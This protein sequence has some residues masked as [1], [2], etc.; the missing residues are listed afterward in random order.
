MKSYLII[1]TPDPSQL[2]QAEHVQLKDGEFVFLD[3][4]RKE[5]FRIPSDGHS[6]FQAIDPGAPSVY[7]K[8]GV[9]TL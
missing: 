6:V 3:E 7:E 8:R 9:L 5:L 2:K 1:P 4:K